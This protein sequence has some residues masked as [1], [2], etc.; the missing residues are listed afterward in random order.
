LAGD[1]EKANTSPKNP[2]YR[3]TVRNGK[4][5][6]NPYLGLDQHQKLNQFF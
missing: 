4:E 2:L 5:I 6:Q 3:N 1:Y